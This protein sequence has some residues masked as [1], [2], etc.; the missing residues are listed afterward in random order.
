MIETTSSTSAAD[1]S[2]VT[3]RRITEWIF[4]AAVGMLAA[5]LYLPAVSPFAHPGEPAGLLCE[6]LGLDAYP[7][8]RFPLTGV[9]ARAT[10]ASPWLAPLC[11]VLSAMLLYGVVAAFI[12]GRTGGDYTKADAARFGRIGGV[13]AAVVFIFTPAVFESATHIEPRLLGVTWALAAMALVIPFVG[14]PK[15]IAWAM[16]L[17]SGAMVGMGAADNVGFLLLAP[18]YL[19]VFWVVSLKRGGRGY[20]ASAIF[21]FAL[22]VA[23]FAWARPA[24]GDFTEF[25]KWQRGMIRAA[26]DIASDWYVVPLF[27]IIPFILVLFSST[28]AFNGERG[29][30]TWTFHGAMTLVTILAAATPLS[31]SIVLRPVGDAPIM[32]CALVAVTAGYLMSYWWGQ[33]KRGAPVNESVQLNGAESASDKVARIIGWSVGGFF[34]AVLAISSLVNRFVAASP[35]EGA[36]AEK[37]AERIVADLD[38]RCWVVTGSFRY[39]DNNRICH[40]ELNAMQDQL[41]IAAYRAGKELNLV[42][43]NRGDDMEYVKRLA[44][45]VAEAKLGGEKLSAELVDVLM[46]HPNLQR[47]R[48]EL[49]VQKWFANDPDAG[50]KAVVLDTPDL[51]FNAKSGSDDRPMEPVAET[52]FFGGDPSRRG[53]WSK[54]GEISAILPVEKGWGSFHLFCLDEN[55]PLTRLDFLRCHLRRHVGLVANNCGYAFH[56]EGLRLMDAGKR[57]EAMKLFDKAFDMYELV[58]NEIDSD[59]ICSLFNE[60]ELVGARLPRAEKKQK[61]IVSRLNRIKEDSRRRYDVGSLSVFYGYICNLDILLKQGLQRLKGGGGRDGVGVAQLNRAMSLMSPAERANAE[62][63]LMSAFYATPKDRE[64]ARSVYKDALIRNASNREAL[65]GMARL[66]LAAGNADAA[67]GY[68]RKVIEKDGD[69][70]SLYPLVAMVHLLK[71]ELGDAKQLLRRATDKDR[72]SM[73]AWYLLAMTVMREIDALPDKPAS[74]EEGDSA[75]VM[76]MKELE[77]VILPAMT[78]QARSSTDFHLHTIRAFLMMR[79]G[80]SDNI[81]SARDSF[82]VASR[83]NPTSATS[84]M[85]LGLDIQLNDTAD[86]ERQAVDTLD[87][88]PDDPLANYVMGSLALQHEKMDEA[89]TYLR[90][91]VAGERKVPLALNDLAEVL[92]R[93]RDFQTAESYARM[94]VEAAPKLYVAWETLGS[95]LMDADKSL[96]EAEKC[97]QTACDLSKDANGRPADV[98]M[99]IALARIQIKRGDIL[100]AKVTLRSVLSR[101]NELTEYEKRE[102]EELRKS[103]K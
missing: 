4:A 30:A 60:L 31:P 29:V 48:L 59:N 100:R 6:W 2:A 68:I 36:F 75:K 65:L 3:P 63:R 99:V 72:T 64:K 61:A 103:A 39:W 62:L 78:K 45:K 74:A 49:F 67:H 95:I 98:R 12:R 89:E 7:F 23:V 94:A 35:S 77:D 84:D 102:F 71:G 18:V 90:R 13:T 97:V 66:E 88:N 15:G 54:W 11:G 10:K 69:D 40:E 87:R 43:L 21:I 58:L 16:P 5:A 101:V 33:T 1:K 50:K 80:G 34:A 20:T 41:R 51:W 96:D 91:S 19:G 93:R 37:I 85:I 17:L 82:I 83:E 56:E 46:R 53:D 24:T 57:D 52:Y 79:K 22:I 32:S 47:K 86:A 14:M 92:R 38:G 27:S 73:E 28:V 9:F 44:D 8:N 26:T 25:V 42:C 55:K 70:P 81:R 76:L